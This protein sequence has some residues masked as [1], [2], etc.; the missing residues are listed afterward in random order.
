VNHEAGRSAQNDGNRTAT[1]VI[2]GVAADEKPFVV[3]ITSVR[4]LRVVIT[5]GLPV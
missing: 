4:K 5:S 2:L 1:L 3:S